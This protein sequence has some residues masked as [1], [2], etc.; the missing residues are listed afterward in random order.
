RSR[1]GSGTVVVLPR[2]SRPRAA[3]RAPGGDA[4]PA[5]APHAAP[6]DLADLSQATSAAP[7]GLHAAY[8]RALERL[9]EHLAGGGYEPYGVAALR[10][11][12]ADH[13]T[14]RGTPTTPDEILVTTGAQHAITRSEEHTSELQSREN[15]VC[16]LLLEK[17]NIDG[18]P[19]PGQGTAP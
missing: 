14:R 16:R 5:P 13:H 19:H 1:T 18:N 2:P 12:L 8:S 17:K 11:A 6:I 3:H 10:E 4:P 9:P 15:L 7:S